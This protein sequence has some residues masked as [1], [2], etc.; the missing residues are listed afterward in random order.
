MTPSDDEALARL[1][2]ALRTIADRTP[3]SG[4]RLDEISVAATERRSR[5][6]VTIV[7]AAA[8][9][10]AIAAPSIAPPRRHAAT[11]P[12]KPPIAITIYCLPFTMY[13]MGEPVCPVGM[14]TAPASFPLALS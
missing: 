11:S 12:T 8:A 2:A 4:G 5:P 9:V 13:V 14:N 3:I 7:S 6:T 10:A 1:R